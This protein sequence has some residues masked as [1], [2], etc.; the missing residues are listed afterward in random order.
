MCAKNLVNGVHACQSRPLL[1]DI[2]KGSWG[3]PGFVISD[4]NSCHSTVECADNGLD[5]ELPSATFYG[6]ALKQAVLNGQVSEA[7]VD[8]HVH[9]VLTVMFRFGLFDRPHVTTPIDAQ[10]DGAVARRIAEQATV[11]LKNTGNVLPLDTRQLHS[12]ALIGPG[13]GTAVTGG[14]GS[15]DVAPLYTVS[16]LAAITKRVGAGV[17]VN[18]A[19][20]MPPVNLGPQPAI[21]GYALNLTA[22]YYPNTTWTGT[23]VLTRTEPWIDTDFHNVA[24]PGIAGLQSNNWSV[25]WTGTLTAPVTGDY[26]LNLTSRGAATLFLDGAVL[27]K[28]KGSFPAGTASATVHLDAGTPRQVQVDYAS[29]STIELGWT[30]PAGADDPAIAQ[31]VSAAKA[32]DVA[33]VFVGD[34]EAEGVDRKTL[35][36]PGDQDALISA[37]AAANPNTIV[38]LN[39]GAPV[40]MPWLDQVAGVLEAWYPGEED[41]NAIA[42]TLFGDADP[43][44]RLPITF[45]KSLADT[46]ANTPAQYPGV[47]GVATYSEGV[48][49]GYRHYDAAGIAPLFPFGYG[50]SYTT[51]RL[52]RLRALGGTVLVDVTNTGRRT[53]SQVVQLYADIP[54]TAD[55]PEPPHQ[56][57]GFAKVTL[58]PGETR[59]VVLHLTARSF[60]HWDTAANAWSTPDGTYGVSAGTSSADLPLTASVRIVGGK[61]R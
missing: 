27:V 6:D 9:R 14:A 59:P 11:L 51:F 25:R 32:S 1:T 50:L 60:A 20:G 12:L 3:Y 40:L 41:G 56:L 37:V 10:A 38:V 44:G 7:T 17:T 30:A 43:A 61:P 34:M 39:T 2:L 4:F 55:V 42:A 28:G 58:R 8:E 19:E 45:P 49:V 16:P 57:V 21:P 53:G 24:P 5:I 46:P 29:Q 35:A 31:A 54:G 36:L 26:T 52:S 48:F 33:V 22:A 23:P 18:Y 13:A 15:P 47:N